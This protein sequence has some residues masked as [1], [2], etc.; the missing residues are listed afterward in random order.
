MENKN[1]KQPP[2]KGIM[3]FTWILI[4]VITAYTALNPVTQKVSPLPDIIPGIAKKAPIAH[5]P[6]G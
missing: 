6:D 4:A 2:G 3:A 5:S 1:N